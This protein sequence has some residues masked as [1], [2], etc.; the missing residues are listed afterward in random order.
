V[1]SATSN[2]GYK[3]IFLRPAQV[4]LPAASQTSHTALLNLS[5]ITFSI[6]TKKVASIYENMVKPRNINIQTYLIAGS[7]TNNNNVT[8]YHIYIYPR[9]LG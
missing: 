6:I 2:V 9:P 7:T 1:Q 4:M 5:Q 3:P 8:A